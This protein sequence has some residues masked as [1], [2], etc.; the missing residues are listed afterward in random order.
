MSQIINNKVAS[1]NTEILDAASIND[2]DLITQKNKTK[3][4]LVT[5]LEVRENADKEHAQKI[6]D[7]DDLY[8]AAQNAWDTE[9]MQ[10]I[11]E[12]TLT[13]EE[14]D[15]LSGQYSVNQDVVEYADYW[16]KWLLTPEQQEKITEFTWKYFQRIDDVATQFQESTDVNRNIVKEFANNPDKVSFGIDTSWEV[17]IELVELGK[18]IK[19]MNLQSLPS[20]MKKKWTDKELLS[21]SQSSWVQEFVY[22]K[23]LS[24]KEFDDCLKQNEADGYVRNAEKE[25]E[26]MQYLAKE[27]WMTYNNTPKWEYQT[28]MRIKM[29][30]LNRL[31]RDFVRRDKDW[32]DLWDL[33]NKN[34][35][36]I[37][38][39]IMIDF[40]LGLN[41]VSYGDYSA[42]VML[43]AW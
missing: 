6:L 29:A 42:S 35:D 33:Y 19:G 28:I 31:W 36:N 16:N 14:F 32:N 21:Q 18:Q 7:A 30:L 43:V 9:T 34:I 12:R 5:M 23:N 22:L 15:A 27:F 24:S 20:D 8:V 2:F 10:K 1:L 40:Y 26:I 11:V 39:A 38:F 13:K 41:R 17:Y 4:V 25:D 3:Q 37:Q